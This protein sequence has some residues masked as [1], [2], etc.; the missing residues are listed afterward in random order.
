ME[1]PTF[2]MEM[3]VSGGSTVE[4]M[5]EVSVVDFPQG[6]SGLWEKG[7][8]CQENVERIVWVGTL[9]ELSGKT[10]ARSCP[11]IQANTSTSRV[12]HWEDLQF[13][14]EGPLKEVLFSVGKEE[15]WFFQW[16]A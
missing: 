12:V 11:W 9:K 16:L 2:L 7:I 15:R 3:I 5:L 13:A 4:G 6:N 8:K 1:K 14:L 10:V